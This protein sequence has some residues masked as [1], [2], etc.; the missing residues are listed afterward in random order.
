VR[1][2]ARVFACVQHLLPTRD[3][4]QRCAGTREMQGCLEADTA[5]CT[6]DQDDLTREIL[7][8]VMDLWVDERIDADN[9]TDLAHFFEDSQDPFG[10]NGVCK[11]GSHWQ[12]GFIQWGR[13]EGTKETGTLIAC[14][15]TIKIKSSM[16]QTT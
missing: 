12:R 15:G 10:L 1:K 11:V 3:D 4:H 5:R 14:L 7:C 8:V 16:E 2:V 13:S 6:S 9:V